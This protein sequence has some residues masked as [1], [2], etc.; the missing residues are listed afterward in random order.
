MTHAS[1]SASRR[2]LGVACRATPSAFVQPQAQAPLAVAIAQAHASSGVRYAV[3]IAVR[4][5]RVWI[6]DAVREVSAAHS[7]TRS[8]D[9]CVRA[10]GA[11][12]AVSW[13]AGCGGSE[14][15][16]WHHRKTDVSE[17]RIAIQTPPWM[18]DMLWARAETEF[19]LGRRAARGGGGGRLASRVPADPAEMNMN[20]TQVAQ[21]RAPIRMRILKKP[22]LPPHPSPA[23]QRPKTPQWWS[24]SRTHL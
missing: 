8:V 21:P 23:M 10:N 9:T 17:P 15:R 20:E 22:M 16:R 18:L 12:E 6:A 2:R 4:S 5:T 14:S 11:T 24:K 13:R 3:R 7:P 19:E 1:T